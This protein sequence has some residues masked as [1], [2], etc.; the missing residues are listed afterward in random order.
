MNWNIEYFVNGDRGEK[1]ESRPAGYVVLSPYS[2][3]PPSRGYRREVA[4]SITEVDALEKILQRQTEMDFAREAEHEYNSMQAAREAVRDR[5]VAKIQGSGVDPSSQPF[6]A[7][8][9]REFLKLR[10]DHP[11]KQYFENQL[12]CYLAV[13][14]DM[15]KGRPENVETVNLDRVYERIEKHS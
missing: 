11:K 7:D 14:H 6:I 13:R 15:S 1:D 10:A 9:F 2:G 8:Y 4:N 3:C 12:N 5:I